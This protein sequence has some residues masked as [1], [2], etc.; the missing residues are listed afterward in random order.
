MKSLML[1]TLVTLLSSLSFAANDRGHCRLMMSGERDELGRYC[2][3]G[4]FGIAYNGYF[5]EPSCFNG[6]AKAQEALRE[7]D[8]C[9]KEDHVGEYA[10]LYPFERDNNNM[11][12]SNAYGVTFRGYT[13]TNRCWGT[14]A[15]A[16]TYMENLANPPPDDGTQPQQHRFR[17][18]AVGKLIHGECKEALQQQGNKTAEN[19]DRPVPDDLV[20]TFYRDQI[21]IP[22]PCI[23]GQQSI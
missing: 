4:Y 21:T 14:I 11:Y 9:D 3:P 23:S 18:A 6:I 13:A 1:I 5:S 12:C 20:L 19:E 22:V 10:I 15:D 8:Y 7:A 2:Y 17:F 16:I